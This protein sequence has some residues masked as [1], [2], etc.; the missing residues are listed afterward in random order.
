M[1]TNTFYLYIFCPYFFIRS[2]WFLLFGQG[3]FSVGI[4][5]HRNNLNITHIYIFIVYLFKLASDMWWGINI[6]SQIQS[7]DNLKVSRNSV[8]CFQYSPTVICGNTPTFS[9]IKIENVDKKV[10]YLFSS[11]RFNI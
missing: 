3:V 11:G 10:V 1:Y 7:E 5:K 4:L 6:Y 2:I 9:G 8:Y